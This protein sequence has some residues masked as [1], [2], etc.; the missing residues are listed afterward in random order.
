MDCWE[1][2][3][4]LPLTCCPM[5]AVPRNLFDDELRAGVLPSAFLARTCDDAGFLIGIPLA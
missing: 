5:F 3:E 4:C 1:G 2:M